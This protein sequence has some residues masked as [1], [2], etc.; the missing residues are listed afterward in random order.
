MNTSLGPFDI[1]YD[2]AT[3]Q[4][5]PLV[6]DLERIYG[7]LRFAMPGS[8]PWV[9]GNFV[10]TMD[11]VAALDDPGREG[12]GEISGFNQHDRM[13]MGLL[14]CLAGAIVSGAGTLRAEPRHIWTARHIYGG[15]TAEYAATRQALGLTVEPL[16]VFVTARGDI[17]L[18]LRVFQS[19]IVPV[20]IVTTAAGEA[21]MRRQVVPPHVSIVAAAGGGAVTAA[22]VVGAI[23]RVAPSSLILVEGGPRLMSD[24]LAEGQ[25][26]E[27]FLTI[28]PQLA[29]R[30]AGSDRP[31]FVFGRLFAPQYPVWATLQ[32][33]RRA[34]SHLMLRYQFSA[35]DNAVHLP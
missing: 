7:P 29:G 30:L 8:R 31:G 4:E 25:L 14:R 32:S 18:G 9:I 3:G 12:G 10:A 20:L 22:S 13:L 35:S 23:Q 21:I 27:L 5:M 34:G 16:N 15:L 6:P 26:D 11:G 17:D 24:F 1:L 19:A 33:V 28:A 2:A